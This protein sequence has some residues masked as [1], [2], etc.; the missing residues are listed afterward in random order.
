MS[1]TDAKD[2]DTEIKTK[3]AHLVTKVEDKPKG[4]HLMGSSGICTIKCK[5]WFSFL[6]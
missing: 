4:I 2:K 6:T 5:Q 1:K 3:A